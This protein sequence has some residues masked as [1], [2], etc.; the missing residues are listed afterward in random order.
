MKLVKLE[1]MKGG[2]FIGNFEPNCHRTSEF[3]VACKS[4]EPGVGEVLHVHK[5][6]TEVTL[7]AIGKARMNGV[8]VG[9]GD[10]VILEP[11][12]ATDFMALEKT[13]TVVVKFPSVTGDKYT[14]TRD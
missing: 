8:A 1:N 7:I 3:E 12:Q 13:I 4:Y 10:I 5:I 14:L 9:S 2:W 11:G 6:G